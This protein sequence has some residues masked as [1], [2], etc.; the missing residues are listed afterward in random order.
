MKNYKILR[1][2]TTM[3][4]SNGG[5]VEAIRSMSL[6]GRSVGIDT[7][8]LCFDSPDSEWIKHSQVTVLPIGKFVTVYGI[9]FR[10][11][12]WLNDNCTNYDLIVFDGLW[13]FLSIGWSCA[14]GKKVPYIVFVHGMLDPYFNKFIFKYLKKLP[15]WFLIERKM[16]N[17]AS[18]VIYTSELERNL[19]L[20]SFPLFRPRSEVCCL[21]VSDQPFI[22][23]VN[24]GYTE[25]PSDSQII[26]RKYGLFLSRINEKKGIELLIEAISKISIPDNFVFVVAG[27]DNDGLKVKL[28]EQ[29]EDLGVSDKIIWLGMISGNEKWHLFKN[30]DFFIL[31]SHQENFGIVVAEALLASAPVVITNKVNIYN[32]ILDCDAGF[33]SDDTVDGIVESLRLWFVLDEKARLLKRSNARNC[34]E[35]NFNERS[36]VSKFRGII[37]RI[38]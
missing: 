21:G 36:S 34:F 13:Q 4:P 29:A 31:P 30:C 7:E 3:D 25:F 24:S 6:A 32:E 22:D 10:Y 37:D 18:A 12:R 16:L 20:S 14:F 26:E 15:F 33:V 2:V 9:N 38:I 27:P 35:V 19:S 1:I 28:Q 17:N 5:V 8:V 11:L 23:Y